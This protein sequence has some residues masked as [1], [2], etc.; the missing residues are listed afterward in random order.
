MTLL[1][2]FHSSLVLTSWSVTQVRALEPL[3]GPHILD[4]LFGGIGGSVQVSDIDA[5][6]PIHKFNSFYKVSC[7]SLSF[8]EVSDSSY[9]EC[10]SLSLLFINEYSNSS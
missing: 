6:A 9:F 10:T 2:L 4:N 5:R 8:C 3:S 7:A 1:L